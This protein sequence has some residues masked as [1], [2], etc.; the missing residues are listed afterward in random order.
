MLFLNLQS[1]TDCLCTGLLTPD[2]RMI[3]KELVLSQ[4]FNDEACSPVACPDLSVT[5]TLVCQGIIA[6]NLRI[7]SLTPIP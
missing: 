6:V 1:V 4:R 5:V 7:S 2:Q 3:A